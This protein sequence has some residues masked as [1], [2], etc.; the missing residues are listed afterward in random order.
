VAIIFLRKSEETTDLPSRKFTETILAV[1]LAIARN[2]PVKASIFIIHKTA[3]GLH[4]R[5]LVL[6]IVVNYSYSV[7]DCLL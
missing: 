4:Y 3:D 2:L 6:S 1:A 7:K 5:F